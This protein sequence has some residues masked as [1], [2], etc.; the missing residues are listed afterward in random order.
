[1]TKT[2]WKKTFHKDYLGAH[3]LEEG[4]ELKV[5]VKNVV[6]KKVKDPQGTEKD[7]NVATF[8]EKIKPM[9]L[10]A[11]ACKQMKRFTGS[12]YIE[13]WNNV[14][15][16]IYAK[17]VKAFGEVTE[18][19]RIRDQQPRMEKPKL[20]PSSEKWNG[21]IN[22]VKESKSTDI[23]TQYYDVSPKHMEALKGAAGIS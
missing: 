14:P 11:T 18:A 5:V 22:A 3:D 9:I 23:V 21:A 8:K 2:H 15:I 17:E 13:D 12:N 1:M 6:I 10:N 7:C 19:L 20:T 16:Q 4:Q